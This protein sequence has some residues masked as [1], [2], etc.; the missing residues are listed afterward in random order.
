VP[1]ERST[2]LQLLPEVVA[3]TRLSAPTIWRLERKGKFPKRL[4]IGLRRVA[5]LAELDVGFVDDLFKQRF[6][7]DQRQLSQIVAIEVK[8]VEGDQDDFGRS[9]LQLVLE[10]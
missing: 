3:R 10:N 7:L 4:I 5:A 6:A 1:A 9:A 8:Q 2:E